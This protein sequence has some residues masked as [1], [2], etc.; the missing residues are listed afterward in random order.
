MTF[1]DCIVAW[2]PFSEL[3]AFQPA[4]SVRT[5]SSYA[6]LTALKPCAPERQQK[7]KISS[8]SFSSQNPEGGA[9]GKRLEMVLRQLCHVLLVHLA[10]RCTVSGFAKELRNCG[11][12]LGQILALEEILRARH[13][14]TGES[15][16]VAGSIA[17]PV[18]S[19]LAPDLHTF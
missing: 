12:Q 7:R 2:E 8:D 4:F 19:W 17:C 10:Q 5:A 18:D 13:S 15:A 6:L 14:K 16:G 1:V 3:S 11:G 9:H